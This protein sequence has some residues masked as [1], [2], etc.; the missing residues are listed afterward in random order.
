MIV[1]ISGNNA[2]DATAATTTTVNVLATGCC[3]NTNRQADESRAKAI[4]LVS[5]IHWVASQ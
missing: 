4:N 3:V 5:F 1:I 2:D